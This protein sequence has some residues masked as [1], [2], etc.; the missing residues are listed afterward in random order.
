M[1]EKAGPW[2]VV[3]LMAGSGS[4]GSMP[5]KVAAPAAIQE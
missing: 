3:G 2:S 5:L 1:E 4:L